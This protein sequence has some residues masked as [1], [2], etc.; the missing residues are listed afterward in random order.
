MTN[1]NQFRISRRK[2]LGGLGTIGVASAGAGLGTTAFFSD[3]ES[4]SGWLQAGRVDLLL[5]YRTTYMPWLDLSIEGERERVIGEMMTRNAVPLPDDDMTYVIGQAPDVR[6]MD[7]GVLSRQRWGDVFRD[8]AFNAR[9]CEDG[10]QENDLPEGVR[11]PTNGEPSLGTTDF[12]DGDEEVFVDLIDVKP[13][14]EGETT[15]SLHLCGNPSYLDMRPI[16]DESLENMRYEPETTA[17]DTSPSVGELAEYLHVSLW[18]DVDCDNFKDGGEDACADVA[19]ILDKSGSMDNDTGS[20]ATSVKWNSALDGVSTLANELEASSGDIQFSLI[21]YDNIADRNTDLGENAAAVQTELDSLSSGG[22]T[23]IAD[24]INVAR[25]ELTGVDIVTDND[26]SPSGNDRDDC[27]KIVVLLTN[28]N[29]N[30]GADA[31]DAADAAKADGIEFYT[32]AYGSDAN[33][34]ILESIASSPDNAFISG[35]DDFDDIIEVF[36]EI[37]QAIVGEICLY[38]GSFQGLIDLADENDGTI[39]LS[40]LTLEENCVLPDARECFDPGVYCYGL[41][42]QLP[43]EVEDFEAL[44]S[45]RV[46]TDGGFGSL[47]DE[48]AARRGIDVEDIDV[49]VTQTDSIH[50][51]VAFDAEQCRHNTPVGTTSGEGFVNVEENYAQVTGQSR[52]RF[53]GANTWEVAVG[54]AIPGSFQ[55]ADYAWVSGATVP[56]M[57]EY[58]GSGGATFTLDGVVVSDTVGTPTGRI[59]IQTKADEATIDVENV[60]LSIDG[61]PVNLDSTSVTASNDDGAYGGSNRNLQ[62]LNIDTTGAMASMPFV[63]KGDVTVTLQNDYDASAEEGVAFDVVVE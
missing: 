8:P 56:W 32:I 37:G 1:D 48:I 50:F 22:T 51:S 45:C 31:E 59:G 20:D 41:K 30:D 29:P 16:L 5:D 3:T 27:D 58:D 52:G 40:A 35:L 46:E 60:M 55:E 39:P 18:Y 11:L 57:Y 61:M 19:I 49:N 7:G 17:G 62:Y 33:Q 4:V 25:E 21:T 23:D 36:S 44:T 26:V 10:F 14:D 24:S 34:D 6:D 47:A 42:W 12:V 2:V 28:G 53:G 9:V 15:F 13:K 43:C 38:E 63:L 54:S